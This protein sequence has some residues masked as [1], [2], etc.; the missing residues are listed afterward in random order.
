MLAE[1]TQSILLDPHLAMTIELG[2]K[3]TAQRSK[4]SF[5]SSFEPISVKVLFYYCQTF[6]IAKEI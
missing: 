2:V 1:F 5:C 6:L 4:V 3:R